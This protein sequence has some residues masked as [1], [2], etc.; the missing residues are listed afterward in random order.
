[1]L[2]KVPDREFRLPF[3]PFVV[4]AQ[5]GWIQRRFLVG[6]ALIAGQADASHRAGID[7]LAQSP[8]QGRL[9]EVS[10][11]VHIDVVNQALVFVP[12]AVVG[13]RVVENVAPLERSLQG[14]RVPKVAVSDFHVQSVDIGCVGSFSDQGLDSSAVF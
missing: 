5:G 1:M 12:Q 11:S 4:V 9:H 7:D 6:G 13:R 2:E 10:R 8:L 14:I 3:G